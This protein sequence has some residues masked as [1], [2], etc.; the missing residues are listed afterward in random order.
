[1]TMTQPVNTLSSHTDFS[2]ILCNTA[3]AGCVFTDLM[4]FHTSYL[5]M[6]VKN[7]SISLT[8]AAGGDMETDIDALINRVVLMLVTSYR[9]AIPAILTTYVTDL[10]VAVDQ[11][12]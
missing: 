11:Y 3:D 12:S 5:R 4:Q 10:V 9:V 1:M 2:S 7:E 6:D 8:A